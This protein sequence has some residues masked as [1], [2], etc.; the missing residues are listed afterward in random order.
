MTTVQALI[1]GIMLAWLPSLLLV[2][3]LLWRDHRMHAM[4]PRNLNGR[5]IAF[6]SSK[7]FRGNLR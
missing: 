2:A 7:P 5:V 4:K 6:R 3:A 1:L